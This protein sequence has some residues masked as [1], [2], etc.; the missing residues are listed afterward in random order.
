MDKGNR[1][2]KEYVLPAIKEKYDLENPNVT[3]LDVMETIFFVA[4]NLQSNYIVINHVQ[5]T[6]F[7]MEDFGEIAYTSMYQLAQNN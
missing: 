4:D 6:G 7:T 2:Y 1:I 5:S 3:F